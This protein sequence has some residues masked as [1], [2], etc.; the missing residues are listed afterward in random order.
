MRKRLD[1]KG[2]RFGKLIV[3]DKIKKIRGQLF[4]KCQCDCG[5]V[6]WIFTGHILRKNGTRSCGCWWGKIGFG[7]AAR[8]EVLH[9]YQ[10]SARVR[11]LSWRLT[12][13]QFDLLTSKS[14][15]FCGRPPGLVHKT[16][17]NSGEFIYNGI[18]RLNSSLGYT[19]KNTVTC[20]SICNYA[21]RDMDLVDFIAWTKDLARNVY[22]KY[23]T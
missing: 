8:N 21:K 22:A 11:N 20:C 5:K 23:Y 7:K 6:K 14:C 12:D 10:K 2:K 4:R 19:S 17:N 13:K 15:F 3:L 1:L 18:D 16:K 9:S